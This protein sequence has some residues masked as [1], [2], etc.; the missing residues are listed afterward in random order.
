MSTA[1]ININMC[2]RGSLVLACLSSRLQVVSAKVMAKTRT[3]GSSRFGF[4]TMATPEQTQRCISELNG[5]ELKGHTI[6][7]ELVR[8][9]GRWYDCVFKSGA[10]RR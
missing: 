9:E 1:A 7:V 6:S 2:S 4:V 10:S 3:H 5:T 8:R